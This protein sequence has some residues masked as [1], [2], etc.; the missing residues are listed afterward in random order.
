MYVPGHPEMC[1]VVAADLEFGL[2][3]TLRFRVVL[4]TFRFAELVE[5]VV[6]GVAVQE[7]H[8]ARIL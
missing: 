2:P 5:G 8:D 1:G 6:E 3:A 7:A 4:P